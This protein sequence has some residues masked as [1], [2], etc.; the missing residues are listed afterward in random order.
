MNR[1]R[2]IV[3]FAV[4]VMMMLTATLCFAEDEKTECSPDEIYDA[5]DKNKDGKISR[6]EWN[7]IDTNKD[8]TITND[9]WDRYKYKSTEKKTSPFQIR[10]YDV[11]GDGTMDKEEFLKH[12]QRLQ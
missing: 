11:Y 5:C 3:V 2:C 10:Y 1:F 4:S 9:E 8:D 12:Y 7:T 6:E